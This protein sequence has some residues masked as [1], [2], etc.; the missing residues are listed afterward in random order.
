MVPASDEQKAPVDGEC[1]NIPHYA[2]HAQRHKSY[3]V[4]GVRSGRYRMKPW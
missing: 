3:M 2:P 1:Y 4:I